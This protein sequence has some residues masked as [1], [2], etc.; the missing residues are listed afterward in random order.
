M[1]I[2]STSCYLVC[3]NHIFCTIKKEN[4]AEAILTLIGMFYLLDIDY[5]KQHEVGLTMMQN[6]FFD[7][8]STPGDL[9]DTISSLMAD[10]T[11]FKNTE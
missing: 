10:Y 6:L 8:T 9:I 11:K 1:L 4:I 3:H 2:D 5:P 7:D